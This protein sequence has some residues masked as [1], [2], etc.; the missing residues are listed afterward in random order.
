[1]QTP[2]SLA[3]FWLLVATAG[4]LPAFVTG[5]LT[6][7]SA[8]GDCDSVITIVGES[9]VNPWGLGGST[10]IT[11]AVTGLTSL[12]SFTYYLRPMQNGTQA[13]DAYV[14]NSDAEAVV[15]SVALSGLP[16]DNSTTNYTAVQATFPSTVELSANTTYYLSFCINGTKTIGFYSGYND[17]G[18]AFLFCSG[19][20]TTCLTSNSSWTYFGGVL[21]ME[22][23]SKACP[24]PSSAS[25]LRWGSSFVALAWAC[26]TGPSACF[27]HS[28]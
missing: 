2:L 16:T 21:T 5:A 17:T 12:E 24:L 11:N 8:S 7:V 13:A 6:P 14:Y 26:L 22:V 15:A 23:S 3:L 28:T 10:C 27:N 9:N 20:T 1:M 18:D 19:D 25:S 4:F